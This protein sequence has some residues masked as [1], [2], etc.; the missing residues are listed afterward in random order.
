MINLIEVQGQSKKWVA[1]IFSIIGDSLENTDCVIK[2]V[3][4]QN[5]NTAKI[6]ENHKEADHE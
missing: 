5:P 6:E 2:L 4:M 1:R 3:I